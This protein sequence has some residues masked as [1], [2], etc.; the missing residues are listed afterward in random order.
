MSIRRLFTSL[1]SCI[2]ATCFW[3]V[4]LT[5]HA[6]DFDSQPSISTWGENDEDTIL[7]E[8]EAKTKISYSQAVK[9]ACKRLLGL[10]I[11]MYFSGGKNKRNKVIRQFNDLA[12]RSHY[13][14]RL[15]QEKISLNFS[16]NL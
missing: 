3:S 7:V 12:E 4:S 15:D 10:D 11:D 6:D 5:V 8:G 1:S 2:L 14:L 9:A 16:L 13:R